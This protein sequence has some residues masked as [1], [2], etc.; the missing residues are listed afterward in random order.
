MEF[1]DSQ[2]IS[3]DYNNFTTTL[4]KTD[5]D[6]LNTDGIEMSYGIDNFRIFASHLNSKTGDVVSL[7]RPNWNLGI[8]HSMDLDN[9]WSMTTNYKFKGKHL[10]VHNVTWQSG[11]SMPDTHLLDLTFSRNIYGIDLGFTVTN[12]LDEDYESPHGFSQDGRRI[13]LGFNR[14]F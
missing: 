4:F 1:S 8:M 3:L 5:V 7:R 13:S 2:E 12:V 14:S 6:R 9:K 10:D 11:I